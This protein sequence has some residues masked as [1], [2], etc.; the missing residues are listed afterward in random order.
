MPLPKGMFSR[1]E[2]IHNAVLR[3]HDGVTLHG[4]E[5]REVNGDRSITDEEGRQEA[6][7]HTVLF[8][9]ACRE[10]K[11]RASSNKISIHVQA[12]TDQTVRRHV[13]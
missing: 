9:W 12:E 11:R 8:V 1:Y 13:K 10:R 3:W 5:L 6:A 4:C 2:G 7:V